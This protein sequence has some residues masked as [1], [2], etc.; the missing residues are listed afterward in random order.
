MEAISQSSLKA[1][2]EQRARDIL[3]HSDKIPLRDLLLVNSLIWHLDE[4]NQWTIIKR[5]L[6]GSLKGYK[7]SRKLKDLDALYQS[8]IRPI[9]GYS[10]HQNLDTIFN[11]IGYTF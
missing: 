5:N 11:Q 8:Y 3:I 6:I 7:K 9:K 2:L 1:V 10:K 4:G